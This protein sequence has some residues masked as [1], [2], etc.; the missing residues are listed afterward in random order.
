MA[1]S[2][3]LILPL[4]L[5]VWVCQELPKMGYVKIS[6][7]HVDN[8]TYHDELVNCR[9]NMRGCPCPSESIQHP[10]NAFLEIKGAKVEAGNTSF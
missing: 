5:D 8:G 2:E 4:V 7:V 3:T 10:L 6:L 1:I 9:N